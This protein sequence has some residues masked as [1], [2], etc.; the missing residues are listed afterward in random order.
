MPIVEPPAAHATAGRGAG[1]VHA[2]GHFHS[3]SHGSH[4]HTHTLGAADPGNQRRLRLALVLTTVFLVAEVVGGLVSNSLALLADAGH[5]FTDVAALGLSLF[6]AWFSRQP[7][8]PEKTYGYL[9]WEILAA[10]FNGTTLLLVSAGI[11][12]EAISRFRAPEPLESGVMLVVATGGLLVNAACAWILH[13]AHEHSLN[14]RGAY[15]HVLG[16]LLGSVGT[17][18]A[19]LVIRWTG[20]L[21]ADPVVSVLVTLLIVRSSWRLMRE[22]IDVLLEA[23]PAHISLGAVRT[24][25]ERIPGVA[26]VHD[27]HVW[28]VTSGMIAMSAHAIVPDGESHQRVLCDAVQEMRGFGIAH[29]TMQIER[30]ELCV[31]SHP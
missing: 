15:L 11:I 23:T 10:F 22:S 13:S 24:K 25:L 2:D 16:D 6:V 20:W 8:T 12:W 30:E 29:V 26:S 14:T 3:H 17:V 27:L 1:H 19:A 4:G 31:D 18:A 5:M 28:T 7:S 21:A 9:R